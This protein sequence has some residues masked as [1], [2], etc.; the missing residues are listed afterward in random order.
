M[1]GRIWTK[2]MIS[3]I[4]RDLYYPAC[5]R[6]IPGHC[7]HIDMDSLD[8][9]GTGSPSDCGVPLCVI[10]KPQEWGGPGLRWAVEPSKKKYKLWTWQ[11][12]VLWGMILNK[13][14]KYRSFGWS[15]TSSVPLV[16]VEQVQQQVIPSMQF[17]WSDMCSRKNPKKMIPVQGN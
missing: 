3:G 4:Q 13:W 11:I 12:T 6:C 15:S 9:E 5:S 10:W 7:P 1:R 16:G 2:I 8:R 17:W 14:L